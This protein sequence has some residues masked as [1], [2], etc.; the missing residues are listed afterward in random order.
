MRWGN[1][2]TKCGE[3]SRMY[4]ARQTRSTFFSRK[5][6]DYQLVVRLALEPFRRNYLRGQSARARLFDSRGAF[7]IA[8][9]NRDFRV[10]KASGVD[11]IRQRFEIR[12]APR[13]QHAD[14]FF[15]DARN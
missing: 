14:S 8:Q 2:A 12:A 15:H 5:R 3:S 6:G 1:A 7:A 11:A 13:K 10:R 9:N 4:P